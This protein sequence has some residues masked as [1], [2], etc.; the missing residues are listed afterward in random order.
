MSYEL[1]LYVPTQNMFSD[2]FVTYIIDQIIV[3]CI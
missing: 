2:Q 3:K 1:L